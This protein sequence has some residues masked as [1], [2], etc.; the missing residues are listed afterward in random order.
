MNFLKKLFWP[1]TAT[2]DFIQKYFKSLVFIVI[3]VLIFG[4]STQ[5]LEHKRP[6]LAKIHLYGPIMDASLFLEDLKELDEDSHIEG[7][8]MVVDSP[9]G[10]I[11]PSIEIAEAVREVA[12]RKK[13]VAYA[14]G[15]MASGSY[16]ASIWS[17]SIIAN[18][19]S[20][21]GSIGV[22]FEGANL[23]NLIEKIGVQPQTVQ[24]GKYKQVGTPFRTWESHEKAELEKVAEE[25]YRMFVSDVATARGLDA[26][27]HETFA[28]AHV[29]TSRQA[30]E[31]GLI[32]RTGTL[33]LAEKEL[34]NLTGIHQ[35]IWKKEDKFEKYFKNLMEKSMMKVIGNL[36]KTLNY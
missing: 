18:P 10:L 17:D 30:R 15:T 31:V 34:I 13:I 32:D 14:S 24:V 21:V 7:I 26:T 4:D 29:F 1:I 35:P 9:G 5:D 11:S 20:I 3:L 8:L 6:N 28:D 2:L 16:Y 23:E 25:Q 12:K 36:T 19:G 33:S 27:Q 22:I